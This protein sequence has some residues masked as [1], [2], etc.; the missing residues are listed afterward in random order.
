MRQL[1]LELILYLSRQE[2]EGE[3]AVVV[4][5]GALGGQGVELHTCL[6]SLQK[7]AAVKSR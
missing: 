6:H 2:S 7:R 5:V 4:A 3:A 1:G